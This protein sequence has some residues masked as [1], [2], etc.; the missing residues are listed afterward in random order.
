[1][2]RRQALLRSTPQQCEELHR[3]FLLADP[4]AAI[5]PPDN[6]SAGRDEVLLAGFGWCISLW[7]LSVLKPVKC[8]ARRKLDY[9]ECRELGLAHCNDGATSSNETCDSIAWQG[10][11]SNDAA[12][13]RFPQFAFFAVLAGGTRSADDR[14]LFYEV[15]DSLA[16]ASLTSRPGDH[17]VGGP[18][19]QRI[20]CERHTQRVGDRERETPEPPFLAGVL[21]VFEGWLTGLEPA[22]PRST[23]WCSNQLSY[24]H[25]ER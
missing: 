10:N 6:F 7:P 18:A 19:M 13:I 25:H 14:Q 23:I 24:S 8:K 11:P 1:M 3:L 17:P 4:A 9:R 22:T 21:G 20:A 15:P 12:R 16:L 2:G 5:G